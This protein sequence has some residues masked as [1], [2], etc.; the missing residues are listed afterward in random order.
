MSINP[1]EAIAHGVEAQAT[2]RN[3]RPNQARD[4]A[5]AASAPDPGSRPNQE[6]DIPQNHYASREIPQDEVQVQRDGGTNGEIVIRYVDASGDVILQV[7]SSELLGM[8]RAI[9]GDFQAQAKLHENAAPAQGKGEK[10]N[11]H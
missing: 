7:P 9:A 10:A 11:G 5:A 8:A 6:V 4:V 2:P 1:V 3:L